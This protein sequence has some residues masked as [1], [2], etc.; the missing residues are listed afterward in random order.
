M[1][2]FNYIIVQCPLPL[3]SSGVKEWQTKSIQPLNLDT[4]IVSSSGTLFFK[5]L[6]DNSAPRIERFD[7]DGV[8]NFYGTDDAGEWH[9]Y[10]AVYSD[11]ELQNVTA[12]RHPSL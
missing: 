1:G 7:Y 9:E 2:M 11:G 10:N 12:Y 6:D 4:I 3:D 8:L 5:S